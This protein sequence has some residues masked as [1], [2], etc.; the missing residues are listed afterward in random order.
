ME[1]SATALTKRIRRK[2]SQIPKRKPEI[3]GFSA[4]RKGPQIV[5][6]FEF[7]YDERRRKKNDERRGKTMNEEEKL[8]NEKDK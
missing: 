8:Q 4:S 1:K 5:Q 2:T 7:R 3:W 6:L